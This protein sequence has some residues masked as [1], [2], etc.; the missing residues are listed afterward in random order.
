[1]TTSSPRKLHHIPK[2]AALLGIGASLAHGNWTKVTG[3]LPTTLAVEDVEAAPDGTLFLSGQSDTEPVI[4]RS[5]NGGVNW[6]QRDSGILNSN[7]IKPGFFRVG[8]FDGKTFIGTNGAGIFRSSNQ[9]NNWQSS[10]NLG[11]G[12]AFYEFA[13][14]SDNTYLAT[15]RENVVGDSGVWITTDGGANWTRRSD[16][17]HPYVFVPGFGGIIPTEDVIVHNGAWFAAVNGT[18]IF[19]STNEGLSWQPVNNGIS[20]PGGVPSATFLASTPGRLWA[21]VGSMLW[22]S[23]DNGGNWTKAAGNFGYVFSGLTTSGNSLYALG[24]KVDGT[25]RIFVTSDG[26]N[27]QYTTSTSLTEGGIV[28]PIAVSENKVYVAT[29]G[30]LF[31]L[32]LNA[33]PLL[34]IPPVILSATGGG[35]FFE[36]ST[37]TL[38]ASADGTGPL[39][40]QW[41]KGTDILSGQTSATLTL[42]NITAADAANYSVVVSNGGGTATSQ[43]LSVL[44][45]SDRPGRFDPS[46]T[47]VGFNGG[48]SGSSNVDSSNG[49]RVRYILMQPDGKFWVGGHYLRGFALSVGTNDNITL[50]RGNADG[51]IDGATN[52]AL[53]NQ[54]SYG[55]FLEPNGSVVVTAF[56]GDIFRYDSSRARVGSG[57]LASVRIGTGNA[58]LYKLERLPDGRFFA[59][60]AF[61]KIIQN[62]N[63]TPVDRKH[64]ALFNA[65]G[66]LDTSFNAS[67]FSSVSTNY[68]IR[69]IAYDPEIQKVYVSGNFEGLSGITYAPK[70]IRLNL[71][72]SHD[73]SFATHLS[74]FYN[75]EIETI[76]LQADGKLLIGTRYSSTSGLRN[77][78]RLLRDGTL[79]PI[80]NPGG[81][82]PEGSNRRVMSIHINPDGGIVIGGEFSTYNGKDGSLALLTQDGVVDPA[83]NQG[84]LGPRNN[85]NTATASVSAVTTSPD[86]QWI[87]LAM[88]GYTYNTADETKAFSFN[89]D[90]PQFASTSLIRV[91]N[92]LVDLSIVRHPEAKTINAGTSTTFTVSAFST[93]GL[94]Y[95][96]LKD[97]SVIP[98]ATAS[99]Y[100]VNSAQL[101]DEGDYSVRVTSGAGTITSRPAPLLTLAEPRF[102]TQPVSGGYNIG[103]PLV[104]SVGA[105]GQGA[106]TYQW[107]RNGEAIIGATSSTLTIG[108]PS[109]SDAGGSYYVVA[110]NSLGSTTS[111][112]A[113]VAM[114]ILGG[115][116]ES[117]FNANIAQPNSIPNINAT[118]A[119]DDGATIVGGSFT[120]AGGINGNRFLVRL[121]ANGNVDT[122]WPAHA[123]VDGQIRSLFLQPDGKILVAGDFSSFDGNNSIKGIVRLNADGTRDTNF[124]PGT[125][126]GNVIW[127]AIT[128]S[129]GRIIAIG[130]FTTFGG[131][132]RPGIVALTSTGALD[133]S[134][135]FGGSGPSLPPIKIDIQSDDRILLGGSFTQ[136]NGQN[137]GNIVRLLPDGPLDATFN[138]T[139]LTVGGGG[140]YLQEVVSL[141]DRSVMVCGLFTTFA[142]TNRRYLV[143][144]TPAGTI[145]PTFLDTTTGFMTSGYI[146]GVTELPNGH[147]AIFGSFSQIGSTF[148]HGLAITN[149]AGV[150]D[151]GFLTRFVP[152]RTFSFGTMTIQ[153]ASGNR[154]GHLMIG[155][156]FSGVGETTSAGVAKVY[157]DPI[158]IAILTQPSDQFL[159]AGETATFT[160]EAV[161]NT[162]ILYR[163]YKDGVLIPGEESPTL[164]LSSVAQS[165]IGSYTVRLLN[166]SGAQESSP[167]KLRILGIPEFIS[168][169][170]SLVLPKGTTAQLSGQA[171]GVPP[172]TYAWT[173]NGIII[174]G[175]NSATLNVTASDASAAGIYRLVA[176]NALGETTSFPTAVS[177]EFPNGGVDTAF[178]TGLP[179]NLGSGFSIYRVV[180][181]TV[182]GFY[183]AG[184]FNNNTNG[185]Q[186]YP[187][188]N[189]RAIARLNP[190]GTPDTSFISVTDGNSQLN[191]VIVRP[192]GKI[193]AGGNRLAYDPE[194]GGPSRVGTLTPTGGLDS[195]FIIEGRD[196]FI[197]RLF[198]LP[199]NRFIGMQSNLLRR[200]N[201]DGTIDTPYSPSVAGGS[202]TAADAHADGTMVLAGTFTSANGTARQ[203]L[204]VISPDGTLLNTFVPGTRVGSTPGAVAIQSDG[205]VVIGGGSTLINGVSGYTWLARFNTDGTIDTGFTP[206][207]YASS[208]RNITGI[209]VLPDGKIVITGRFTLGSGETQTINVARL[210]AD[211]TLDTDYRTGGGLAT[212]TTA[213]LALHPDSGGRFIVTGNFTAIGGVS[214]RMI[215]R[216]NG[217]PS[218][219]AIAGLPDSSTVSPGEPFRLAVAASGTAP[220]GF[221]WFLDGSPIA[222]ANS[223]S[224]GKSSSTEADFGIYSV[225]VTHFGGTTTRT[226][227]LNQGG[228]PDPTG[229]RAWAGE[230][231]LT[232]N[233]ALPGADPDNDGVKNVIEF[234]LGSN[235]ATG[236]SSGLFEIDADPTGTSLFTFRTAKA[237]A[238]YPFTVE[239]SQD[240]SFNDG[241]SPD[242]V[243][244]TGEDPLWNYWTVEIT[245]PDP[246]AGL[247]LRL[248]VTY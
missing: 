69:S 222:G 179:A 237:A 142:G 113:T 2:V 5:T 80:F 136:F 141:K 178:D 35:T 194:L 244:K 27:F 24:F 177:V 98:G 240:L 172:L 238:A 116:A 211:G 74:N 188:T 168:H 13:R 138:N 81:T 17:L 120:N 45:S 183:V 219:L 97:G 134:F 213:T 8:A 34:P 157:Y 158:A 22:V 46:F 91:R 125:N 241:V 85:M 56:H 239:T 227:S 236:G 7:N 43:T 126:N 176:T 30:G 196:F 159:N 106:L 247:F 163:W 86:N 62:G 231:G 26:T 28:D 121:L 169:P 37:V 162:E 42:N 166:A 232:G 220:L 14:V 68:A 171:I 140:S 87:Y 154:L 187:G 71:D 180:P 77:F 122:S 38:S 123:K 72:G 127:K 131:Q 103:S 246:V 25:R 204:A 36:G 61:D 76:A 139:T 12:S 212:E 47:A 192:D 210:N 201:A 215:A 165:D 129:T 67:I 108:N 57:P 9:G 216:Y 243:T 50:K 199:D 40:Y 197:S 51:S 130:N 223:S 70:V 191:D 248:K 233:D 184:N 117:T 48:L 112:V 88:G 143:K 3:G 235:P 230:F 96:W 104:L 84:G 73:T 109:A 16:G 115:I 114:N 148:T 64:I 193:I 23:T 161:G 78:E 174:A 147:L 189:N 203:R 202:I 218:P 229:I 151:N 124:N 59:A 133:T 234:L 182:G 206:P 102:F 6:T 170:E 190:D 52:P 132:A 128:Q 111:A 245:P 205:K 137:C 149:S 164:T 29:D 60:G 145:D 33:S 79:D 44:V 225:T 55:S 19:R 144:L 209:E 173:R 153:A 167:A 4:F 49:E 65:D 119:L 83:F 208:N 89:P 195:T 63:P 198:A 217:D 15:K 135:S 99:S 160:V 118:L 107:Y 75:T 1:M 224:Y 31:T 39:S 226:A 82:G 11:N 186:I 146:N 100:T 110:T 150:V 200:W 18:G 228:I 20:V 152:T 10:S 214:K 93:T 242:S 66:T 185:F 58:K 156:S 105:V 181:D 101:A 155:G 90:L 41:R 54:A 92:K 95:Q 32:D 175:A 94:S 221:Q 53:L 21:T 207:V